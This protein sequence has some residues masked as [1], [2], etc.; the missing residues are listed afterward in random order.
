MMDDRLRLEYIPLDTALLWE[1][2]RKLHDIDGLVK[3]FKK[4]G[5]KDPMKYEPELNEGRGGFAEGNGRCE[6]LA[7]M[8]GKGVNPPRGVLLDEEGHWLVPVL[9][10]VD[11]ASE[12]AAR[13]YGI[14]HN[15]L[16]LKGG[17]FDLSDHL[18]MWDMD[19]LND[20]EE[21]SGEDG[22]PVS[23]TDDD[24][25]VMLSEFPG[26][27]DFDGIIEE[28]ALTETEGARADEK[29]FYIEFY[30]DPERWGE[31]CNLLG[32]HFVGHSSHHVDENIFYE[33]VLSYFQRKE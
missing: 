33:M 4:H 16:T 20:L 27:P 18:K 31:M 23:F 8:E 21:L 22:L 29:Y 9:F 25:S 13:A 1:D 5:F 12:A 10:G 3:S 30:G 24:I 17:D 19:F 32:E 28:F 7:R 14:D 2:N 15:S 11:A 26:R 6:A